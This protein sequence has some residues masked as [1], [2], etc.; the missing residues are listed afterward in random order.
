M[1]LFDNIIQSSFNNFT[2]KQAQP[3]VPISTPQAPRTSSYVSPNV[4]I[5]TQAKQQPAPQAQ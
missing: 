5:Q 1:N 4:P 3:Q 2:G